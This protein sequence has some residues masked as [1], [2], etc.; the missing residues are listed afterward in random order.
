MQT[1]S[2][3]WLEQHDLDAADLAEYRAICERGDGPKTVGEA[4]LIL[5]FEGSG[6]PPTEA[7]S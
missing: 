6:D 5:A 1:Y 7:A 4:C 3:R 2:N